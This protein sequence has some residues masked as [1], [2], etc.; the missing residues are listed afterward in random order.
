[1]TTSPS[2]V[3]RP[4]PTPPRSAPESGLR[5]EAY[6]HD[7]VSFKGACGSEFIFA[8]LSREWPT[9][10]EMTAIRTESGALNEHDIAH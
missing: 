7:N 10:P 1:M 3:N 9:P 2:S 5:R 6:F 4:H 8:L